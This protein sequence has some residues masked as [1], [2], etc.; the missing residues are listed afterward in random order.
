MDNFEYIKSEY[1]DKSISCVCKI[2]GSVLRVKKDSTYF[3][4]RILVEPCEVCSGRLRQSYELKIRSITWDFERSS[5]QAN[6][7]ITQLRLK[8]EA[9]EHSSV[10]AEARN[11]Y[12][13]T[14][15]KYLERKILALESSN[16]SAKPCHNCKLELEKLL[17]EKGII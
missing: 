15:I 9:L 10:Q 5:A 2:C 17:R 4:F 1:I 7:Q 12:L 16:T 14:V 13:V 8:I 6:E 11:K 3:G